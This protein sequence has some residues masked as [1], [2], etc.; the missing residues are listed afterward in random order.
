MI[1]KCR[2]NFICIRYAVFG[3]ILFVLA[4]IMVL[5]QLSS[6]SFPS[7]STIFPSNTIN[8]SFTV[9][10]TLQSIPDPIENTRAH[11]LPQFIHNC[12]DCSQIFNISYDRESNCLS[13]TYDYVYPLQYPFFNDPIIIWEW[14]YTQN[15]SQIAPDHSIIITMF[16][17]LNVADR[18]T[19]SIMTLTRGKYELIIVLDAVDTATINAIKHI[20]TNF[21]FNCNLKEFTNPKS[22]KNIFI[23]NQAY[24]EQI[25]L[26]NDYCINHKK[27]STW[28]TQCGFLQRIVLIQ[29]WGVWEASANNVGMCISSKNTK[30]FIHVQDDMQMTQIGWNINMILPL[31]IFDDDFFSI[32][33]RCAVPIQ[34]AFPLH[35]NWNNLQMPTE[36]AEQHG[37]I[38]NR[39]TSLVG[40]CG[41]DID[42]P[43][44]QHRYDKRIVY[45]RSDSNRGPFAINASDMKKIGLF[46][47]RS[48]K[49]IHD[50]PELHLRS[51]TMLHKHTGFFPLQ[52]RADL[53][54]GGTRRKRRKKTDKEEEEW[55]SYEKWRNDR[56]DRLHAFERAI[57]DKTI[58]NYNG[59][60]KITMD[61]IDIYDKK[62]DFCQSL[63]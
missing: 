62:H 19:E 41:R 17:S 48:F 53:K 6:T 51:M 33:G 18:V 45:E 23:E 15:P 54:W 9:D 61:M 52:F 8:T 38:G 56:G 1:I 12:T 24:L 49:L 59:Q 36:V 21:D 16:D 60:R 42:D 2:F 55:R 34:N 58:A 20:I 27:V 25:T 46:N 47:E 35:I 37:A 32:S 5:S 40:R 4:L 31:A 10:S 13:Y 63:M 7:R 44:Q 43:L 22:S 50:I 11:K 29:A 26:I 3:L 14:N 30:Y 57:K 39:G 28:E